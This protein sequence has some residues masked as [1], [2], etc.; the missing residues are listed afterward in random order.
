MTRFAFGSLRATGLRGP[1]LAGAFDDDGAAF[2]SL[3][4]TGS[5][6]ARAA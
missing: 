4:A 1:G 6:G 3:R 2:G 5:R